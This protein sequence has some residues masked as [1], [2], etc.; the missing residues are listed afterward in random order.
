MSGADGG[1]PTGTVT[2]T[3]PSGRT[4]C[5]ITLADGTGSC[6]LATPGFT[7][8]I[9]PN[10]SSYN[11]AYQLTATYSGDGNYVAASGTATVTVARAKTTTTLSLSKSPV[12]YRHENQERLTVSVS[13]VGSVYPTG[14]VTVMA[15]RTTLCAIRLTKG[16]GSCTL[17]ASKL[18][19]GTYHLWASYP[20]NSDYLKSTSSSKTLKVAS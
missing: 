17:I 4:L 5:T 19:A 7:G 6:V 10:T 8:T 14:S 13:H 12:T 16:T 1:T 15:G 18:K 9:P 2:V 11:G 3:G 20:G